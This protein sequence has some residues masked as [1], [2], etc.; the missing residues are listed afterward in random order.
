MVRI[1]VFSCSHISQ[2]AE[3]LSPLTFTRSERVKS[4][5]LLGALFKEGHSYV[6]YPF[7]VVWLE[8]PAADPAEFPAQISVSVSKRNFKTAV[9]RNRIKRRIREAYRLNKESWYAKLGSRSQP[10]AMMLIYIAKEELPYKD[11][12]AGVLK[13]I[14]KF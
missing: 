12:E 8:A 2:F 7:R 5:K 6:A 11:I 14:R 9:A 13:M 10:V 4:R 3:L 1:T